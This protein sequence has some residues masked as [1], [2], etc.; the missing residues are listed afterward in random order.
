MKVLA[1]KRE[2]LSQTIALLTGSLRREKDMPA[3]LT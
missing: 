3:G 1:E 2:E